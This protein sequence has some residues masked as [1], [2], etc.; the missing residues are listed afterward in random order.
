[1]ADQELAKEFLR[2]RPVGEIPI[3]NNPTTGWLTYYD[4]S[5][6][7]KRVEIAEFQALLANVAKP[8]AIADPT[9]TV[10]G[11]YKPTTSGTYANAGG[12]EALSG[13]D[14]L[15]YFDG[16]AWVKAEVLMP[17]V[18]IEATT[19]DALDTTKA[20]SG[21][22]V[23]EYV[24]TEI[25]TFAHKTQNLV[26]Y[27]DFV[28]A[29]YLQS[30]SKVVLNPSVNQLSVMIEGDFIEGDVYFYQG[31]GF[32][33]SDN[34]PIVIFGDENDTFLSSI[35]RENFTGQFTIPVGGAERIYLRIAN[36]IDI[37]LNP[38]D[39][40]YTGIVQVKKSEIET[41]FEPYGYAVKFP[42][43]VADIVEKVY[44]NYTSE[45]SVLDL[46]DKF[47]DISPN[48]LNPADFMGG[49]WQANSSNILVYQANINWISVKQLV[50]PNTT[51]FLRR[52]SG[53]GAPPAITFVDENNV[54]ISHI[55][56]SDF[57][58]VFTTPNNCPVAYI[59]LANVV[60][61]GA[62]PQDPAV[63]SICQLSEGAIE[64]PYVPYGSYSIKPSALPADDISMPNYV[65]L[66]PYNGTYAGSKVT[67]TICMYYEHLGG[68][69][70]VG[71]T[72][73]YNF[74]EYAD[75]TTTGDFEGGEVV[76][77][78]GS[79]LYQLSEGVMTVL[80]TTF[81]TSAESEFVMSTQGW[82]GGFH[83]H[84]NLD[85]VFFLI[86][87]VPYNEDGGI[88]FPQ[89]DLIPCKS[90]EY[91]QKSKL[92]NYTDL[93]DLAQRNKRTVFKNGGYTTHTRLEALQ[94]FTALIYTGIVCV[95]KYFEKVTT[96]NG[97]TFT[98]LGSTQFLID[99][100]MTRT[101]VY[102][103]SD[104]HCQVTNEIKGLSDE[105]ATVM[106]WDRAS[107]TKYYRKLANYSLAIGETLETTTT[108]EITAN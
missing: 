25:T 60:G 72:L 16:S 70:Y 23:A 66:F 29:S 30:G 104:Y 42:E 73:Y 26:N 17:S 62:N 91:V 33:L 103:G 52:H 102:G 41:P 3:V 97:D 48:L 69:K 13:Y 55:I 22:V 53:A 74:M 35:L 34:V 68:G 80:S 82:V 32:N 71:H 105:T 108:I 39:N 92:K 56:S 47:A 100:R 37:G 9:P 90:F 79:K 67:H 5:G 21:K 86:D 36:V 7:L 31:W 94:A 15:F 81:I 85:K 19:L 50:K 54:L 12:L 57:N 96:D 63:V 59:R 43:P 87:G 27:R 61:I 11:W 24:E 58:G 78:A 101:V 93:T 38:T 76:R 14:T 83:G 18:A 84:E 99:E 65:S 4:G 107:D 28:G 2:V 20:T 75:V 64:K 95:G 10:A 49:A 40:I 8:L 51:Y 1:M 44:N 46:V 106:L 77:Y 98:P 89:A 6:D 45:G 88:V